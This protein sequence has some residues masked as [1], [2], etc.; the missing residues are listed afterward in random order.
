[1]DFSAAGDRFTIQFAHARTGPHNSDA[2]STGSFAFTVSECMQYNLA[3]TYA[4]VGGHSVQLT[5]GLH[6]DTANAML[7]R[8]NQ[9]SQSTM[10]QVFALGGN[11]GDQ[12]PSIPTGSATGNLAPGHRYTLTYVAAIF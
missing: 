1:Y 7:F 10:N 8:D 6:D 11:R 12:T 2:E 5:V 3:A 9:F 4:L